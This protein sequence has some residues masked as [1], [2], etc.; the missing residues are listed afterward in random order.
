MRLNENTCLVGRKV[1][2]VPYK[3]HH[4]D[5]YHTW[6]QD[7]ELLEK[8]ASEPL[9]LK[10]E[11]EMQDKWWKDEDKCTFIVLDKQLCE[12]CVQDKESAVDLIN[13]VDRMTVQG[14]EGKD[15]NAKDADSKIHK[16]DSREADERIGPTLAERDISCMVGDVNLF[17]SSNDNDDHN[18]GTN[19]EEKSVEAEVEV[20]IAEP[21]ARGK[22]MGKE[23]VTMMLYYAFQHLSVQTFVVKI[24]ISNKESIHLFHKLGFQ[25]LSHSEVF[26][27]TTYALQT[28]SDDFRNNVLNVCSHVELQKYS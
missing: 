3:K 10:E 9:S 17:F 24:G 27:E 28:D 11:F 12:G 2:L 19:P 13:D 7:P 22:G 14:V 20:M 25:Y 1:V 16:I 15:A 8:T 6:M 23:S 26:Q 21:S 4:V 5:K 18:S